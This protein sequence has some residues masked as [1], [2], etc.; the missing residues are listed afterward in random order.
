[1]ANNFKELISDVNNAEIK[2]L[3]EKVKICERSDTKHRTRLD[4]YMYL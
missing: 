4:L 1:M 3:G 2:F